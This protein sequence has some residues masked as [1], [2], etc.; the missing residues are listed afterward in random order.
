[1]RLQALAI[2]SALAL[3]GCQTAKPASVAGECRVFSAP[4]H[5]VQGVTPTDRRWINTNIEAGIASCGWARPR[6]AGKT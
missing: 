6:S 5:P 3:A 1:M 2:I 4:A